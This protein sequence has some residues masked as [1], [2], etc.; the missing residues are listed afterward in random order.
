M[1]DREA[2]PDLPTPATPAPGDGP[3]AN[4]TGTTDAS[5]G[6]RLRAAREARGLSIPECA[7]RLHLP[8]RVLRRLE[9]DDWGSPEH[10]VF[11]R[12]AL[13]GYAHLLDLPEGS[14][15]AVLRQA[16]PEAQPELVTVAHTTPA[17]WLLQRY[18]TAA[19]YIVLTAF[20]A[21]PLVILGLRGG[22]ERPATRMVSLDHAANTPPPAPDTGAAAGADSGPDAAPD[23]TPFRASMTPF[24]AIGLRDTEA[25]PAPAAPTQV[26][27]D[28]HTLA[29][30]ATADCWFA[31]T[32]A[33]G[34][35]LDSGMLHAGDK[36]TWHA[37]GPLHVTLGNAG[38]VQVTED[39]K[40]VDLSAFGRASVARLDL[41]AG[42]AGGTESD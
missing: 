12:G 26:A 36:R 31:I 37:S 6:Q 11:L 22:L 38:G 5:L 15:D 39:G 3:A 18:G 4:H 1:T 21:V 8:V 10:F 40:A 42:A 16:A 24:A 34:K 20:I 29:I 2:S 14:C 27:T 35:Q 7:T 9:S 13:K 30:S 17:R 28:Q 25:A 19:I 32:D 23:T 33:G 41:F